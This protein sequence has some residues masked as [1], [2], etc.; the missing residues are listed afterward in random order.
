MTPA[1]SL[2]DLT[3]LAQAWGAFEVAQ[4]GQLNATREELQLAAGRCGWHWKHDLRLLAFC[5][6]LLGL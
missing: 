4:L 3:R 2:T 5:R 1:P 6:Q